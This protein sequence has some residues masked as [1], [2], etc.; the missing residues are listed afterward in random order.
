MYVVHTKDTKTDLYFLFRVESL[1]PLK[2][3]TISWKGVQSPE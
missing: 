3:V 1:D 2:S